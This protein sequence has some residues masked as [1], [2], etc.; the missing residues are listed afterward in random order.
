M[1]SPH[2]IKWN[3]RG[4][5][6]NRYLLFR[7]MHFSLSPPLKEALRWLTGADCDP[8]AFQFGVLRC[9]ARKDER[10]VFLDLEPTRSLPL[11][12][13]KVFDNGRFEEKPVEHL[14]FF[15]GR[16]FG[17]GEGRIDADSKKPFEQK[18]FN[19]TLSIYQNGTQT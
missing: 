17:V 11:R 4:R 12:R 13:Q 15:G 7:L 18:S 10:R 8:P 6:L 16:N 1:R 14:L 19:I 2:D 5:P 3:A 9:S